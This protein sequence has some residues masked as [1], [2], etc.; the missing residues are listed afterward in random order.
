MLVAAVQGVIGAFNEDPSPFDQ[1]GGE[2]TCDRA[3]NDLLEKSRVH[4]F[5]IALRVPAGG[6]F[7]PTLSPAPAPTWIEQEKE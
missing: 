6:L 2:K 5:F 4:V 7:P 1:G 3:E